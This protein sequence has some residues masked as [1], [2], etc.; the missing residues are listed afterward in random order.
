MNRIDLN[1]T[2]ETNNENKNENNNNSIYSKEKLLKERINYFKNKCINNL[3]NEKYLQAYNY[4]V[5]SKKNK[6]NEINNRNIRDNLIEILGKE[7]IGYWHLLDQ[8]LL[9]ED[10][11]NDKK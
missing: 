11:L 6:N 2:N 3:T 5:K 7:D 4:L 8:I 1:D 10:M 9:F